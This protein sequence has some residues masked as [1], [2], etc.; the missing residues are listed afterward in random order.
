MEKGKKILI[1]DKILTKKELF[2]EKEKI[3]KEQA[4]LP[5]E[6]KI[7]ILISL[8]RLAYGWGEKKDVIIWRL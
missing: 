3:R 6:E 7:K 4:K 2:K 1:G 8:Q 5:F